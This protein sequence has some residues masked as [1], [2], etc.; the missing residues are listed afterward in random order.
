M[1]YL[2]PKSVRKDKIVDVLLDEGEKENHETD[3]SLD[4]PGGEGYP[5]AATAEKGKIIFARM[6]NAVLSRL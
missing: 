4:S 2:S 5:S 6:V 1:L 3:A